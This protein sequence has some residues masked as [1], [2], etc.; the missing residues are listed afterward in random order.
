DLLRNRFHMLS[1]KSLPVL[2]SC[3]LTLEISIDLP[4]TVTVLAKPFPEAEVDKDLVSAEL[5][6]SAH[7]R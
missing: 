1:A 7:D 6:I 2:I 3:S 4:I 5:S